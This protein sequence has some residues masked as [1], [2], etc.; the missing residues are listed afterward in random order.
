MNEFVLFILVCMAILGGYA[1]ARYRFVPR[2]D[3]IIIELLLVFSA[4]LD[5]IDKTVFARE[6][7]E[8]VW[9]IRNHPMAALKELN[10]VIVLLRCSLDENALRE[11][12]RKI[13]ELYGRD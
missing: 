7:S 8:V 6:V 3:R 10:D 1:V 2:A 9:A 5:K 13:N 11:I 4:S 12:D